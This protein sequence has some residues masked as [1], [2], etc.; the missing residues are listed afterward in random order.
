[1]VPETSTAAGKMREGEGDLSDQ[2][3]PLQT[4]DSL[5]QQDNIRVSAETTFTP[6]YVFM[7]TQRPP[8]DDINVRKAMAYAF[9]YQE[10]LNGIM[11]GDSTQMQGP[12]PE[13]LWGHNDDLKVYEKDLDRAEELLSQS[14]YSGDELDFTYT[15]VNGLNIRENMGL[16]LQS[17]LDGIG[18]DVSIQGRPWSK[19]TSL[20]TDKESSPQM[21][22]TVLSFSYADPD[23]FL[24]PAWHSN[25]HGSW[26][27]GSWYANDRV[28]ELLDQARQETEREE[29]VSLYEEA[30]QLINEDMPALFTMN[31]ASR[32]AVNERLQGFR[33]NGVVGY[34][35]SPHRFTEQ[36]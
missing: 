14:Q 18:V 2:Y 17:D 10:L 6:M 27:S 1:M 22:A 19:I 25:S 29:R 5:A 15:Y 7:H 31:Q 4:F 28:D 24:Y 20:H 35:Q 3:L 12:L 36:S 13:A 11:N 9:D 23:N 30:Q 32:Y 21:I 8:F 33:D 26:Q 16:M 34:I